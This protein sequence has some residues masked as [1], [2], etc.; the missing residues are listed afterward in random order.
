MEIEENHYSQHEVNEIFLLA[1]EKGRLDFVKFFLHDKSLKYHVD[2]EKY[3]ETGVLEAIYSNRPNVLEYLL[4]SPEV[5]VKPKYDVHYT[6]EQACMHHSA[7]ILKVIIKDAE[8]K[9]IPISYSS[10][11]SKACE[12][13]NISVV[14]YFTSDP[15]MSKHITP[16]KEFNEFS[17]AIYKDNLAIIDFFLFREKRN[18]SM[19]PNYF[20]RKRKA[21]NPNL[22]RL[23]KPVE[24]LLIASK[25]NIDF[26]LKNEN[27]EQ[28]KTP[29]R[30]KV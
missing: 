1:C 26:N 16:E 29:K 27:Q 28:E 8:N 19:N 21:F 13:A 6:Y 30:I 22:P 3:G 12:S 4:L 5:K 11:F 25:L 23:T 18:F 24:N 15:E 17:K 14:E 2:I 7:D 10:G 20:L 9:K